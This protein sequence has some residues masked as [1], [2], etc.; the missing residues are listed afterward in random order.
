EKQMY[1]CFGCH[2]GGNVF[3]FLMEHNKTSFSEALQQLADRAGL[4]VP[5]EGISADALARRKARQHDLMIMEWATKIYHQQLK[6]ETLGSSAREYLEKRG[7]SA[8]LIDELQIGF[9]LPHWS[10]LTDRAAKEGYSAEELARVGMSVERDGGG[11]YDR[12]RNRVMFPIHN[13]AGRV[14]AFGGRV[15]DN[16]QPKYLNSPETPLFHKGKELFGLH[17]AFRAIA[18]EGYAIIVEGYMDA[19]TAWQFGF[20]HTIASLGTALTTEQAALLKKYTTAVV[21]CFDS[22]SA[23]QNASLRGVDVLR[24]EGFMVRV[25][26]L[27]NGLDPDDY[28]RQRGPQKFRELITKDAMPVVEYQVKRIADS[29]DL[30]RPEELGSLAKQIAQLLA[31]V[32]NEVER[33]VYIDRFAKTYRIPQAAFADELAKHSKGRRTPSKHIYQDKAL[34]SRHASAGWVKAALTLIRIMIDYPVGRKAILEAWQDIGFVDS[35]QEHL[36]K[37]LANDLSPK[38][39]PQTI[40]HELANELQSLLAS[41]YISSNLEEN[42]T[43]VANECLLKLEQHAVDLEILRQTQ[44]LNTA[45]EPLQ[46]N[47]LL[48]NLQKLFVLKNSLKEKVAPSKGGIRLE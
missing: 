33:Q 47:I 26:V 45:Y 24:Q 37:W 36:C 4:E 10:T 30:G 19:C 17:R 16:T 1:Y 25:A 23:G 44:L 8:S 22:D 35:S 12:F 14:I 5:S 48:V 42:A 32:N 40:A 34:P 41:A 31:S 7:L 11:M 15:L 18:Q 28:L 43:Q 39:V 38:D 3:S 29:L 46:H 21:L 13:R 2:A 20:H 27:E 6:N 9:A